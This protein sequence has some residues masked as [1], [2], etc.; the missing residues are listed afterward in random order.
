MY[1][2]IIEYNIQY[3]QYIYINILLCIS[4]CCID[5][6]AQYICSCVIF[7]PGLPTSSRH[8]S[9]TR[10]EREI[11]GSSHSMCYIRIVCSLAVNRWH[12]HAQEKGLAFPRLTLDGYAPFFGVMR[13][14][15]KQLDGLLV[16]ASFVFINVLARYMIWIALEFFYIVVGDREYG[17][18]MYLRIWTLQLENAG[19]W[20]KL[21]QYQC[22]DFFAWRR[23]YEIRQEILRRVLDKAW[24]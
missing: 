5:D 22:V 10:I 21:T 11:N 15:H 14:L 17:I 23:S 7:T 9:M 20:G 18:W 19:N 16:F 3:I 1:T 12:I 24:P 6:I 2:N 8:G 13:Q 4:I